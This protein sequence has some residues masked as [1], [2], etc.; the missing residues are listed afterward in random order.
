MAGEFWLDDRQ[1]AVIAP[2]LP[3]N[4]PGAHRTDDRRVISGIIHLL[5]TGCRWQDCPA[6]YGPST[7]IYNRFHRWSAKGIWRQLFEALVQTTN[8]DIHMIDSTTAKAHRSAAGGK[9]GRKLKP[10]VDREA[11]DRQKYM[12]L[13][14]VVAAQSH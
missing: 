3:T 9:G 8:R 13:S 6:V 5:R 12:L 4:Q 11:A 10:S 14:M 2:L 7:T 1:W